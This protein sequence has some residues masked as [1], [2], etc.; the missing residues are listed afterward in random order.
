MAWAI[1]LGTTNTGVAR[2]DNISESPRLVDLHDIFPNRAFK[3][4]V[5]HFKLAPPW[6]SSTRI[7]ELLAPH[8]VAQMDAESD[9]AD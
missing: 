2:W 3:D 6:R 5:E 8:L 7:A 1:D 4:R 9:E